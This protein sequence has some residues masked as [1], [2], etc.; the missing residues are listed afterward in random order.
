[1]SASPPSPVRSS[2]SFKVPGSSSLQHLG[3]PL[4]CVRLGEHLR[5]PMAAARLV[6][7][8]NGP[9]LAADAFAASV[10][11]RTADESAIVRPQEGPENP[12]IPSRSC[13]FRG[14][15]RGPVF[16]IHAG[17]CSDPTVLDVTNR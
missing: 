17:V 4:L 10:L 16:H 12:A 11:G 13:F 5:T 14:L 1:M 9:L 6:G 7:E 8:V 15:L 2:L 3:W